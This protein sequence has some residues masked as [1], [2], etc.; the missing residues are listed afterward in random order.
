[1]VVLNTRTQH[2]ARACLGRTEWSPQ[3]KYDNGGGKG[4]RNRIVGRRWRVKST[5][6]RDLKRNGTVVGCRAVKNAGARAP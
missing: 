2:A 4:G 1:M 3:L 5:F 6:K